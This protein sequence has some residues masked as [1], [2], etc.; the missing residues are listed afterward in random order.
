MKTL[1]SMVLVAFCLNAQ[2]CRN[3]YYL[4]VNKT[5]TSLLYPLAVGNLI[6]A[7]MNLAAELGSPLVTA[8]VIKAV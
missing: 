3:G 5:Q 8:D 2:A 4:V 6:T 1:L 7:A